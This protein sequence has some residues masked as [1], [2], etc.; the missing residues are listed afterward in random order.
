[1]NRLLP[2]FAA[3]AI[4]ADPVAAANAPSKAERD[5][6]ISEIVFKNYPPR[7]LAAG[8]QGAVFF[9]VELDRD[10]HPISC[11]VTHGSGHPLLDAETCEL[12]VQHA[13]FKS[14]R[15]A[16]GRLT[17]TKAEGVVN[18][19]ILG[20][21]Q[22]PINPIPLTDNTAP[23][24]Q[25][26]KK[27]VRAGTLA[28]VERTCMTATEWARRTDQMKQSWDDLQGRKGSTS[29]LPPCVEPCGTTLSNILSDP[30]F[31]GNSPPR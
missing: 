24:K 16:H 26:C 4:I 18:W 6:Q 9:V 23:E 2:C 30:D 14:A 28:G 31:T 10:A 19:A 20:R 27:T 22:E 1:M 13:V 15:D 25:I 11:Q 17:K 21:A 29:G 12:I 8:E 7:A 5:R 3:V